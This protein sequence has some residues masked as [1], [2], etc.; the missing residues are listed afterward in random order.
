L[1]TTN[2]RI[3]TDRASDIEHQLI[4][5][6]LSSF[7]TGKVTSKQIAGTNAAD[8]SKEFIAFLR[9]EGRRSKTIVKYEGI[10]RKFVEFIGQSNVGVLSNVTLALVDAYRETYQPVLGERSMHFEGSLLKRFFSWCVDRQLMSNNPLAKRTFKKPKARP[11]GGPSLEQIDAILAASSPRRQPIV[12][13]AAFA[14]IRIGEILRLRVEDI[15]FDSNWIH[16]VSRSGYETKT[17]DTWKVPIHPRLRTILAEVPHGKTGWYFTALPSRKYPSG[18]HQVNPRDANA[19]FGKILTKLGIPTGRAVGFTFHSL[20]SSFKTIC[21]HSG[22]PKEVVDVWQ[23]HSP[24]PA[25]SNLYYKLSD[26]ESQRLIRLAK[27]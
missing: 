25:A 5:G 22:I 11:R 15:D 23:N 7:D 27:F 6:L 16:V 21:I 8:A 10:L 19:N 3:A 24:G 14:G 17:G 4:H 20:R 1:E 13:V 18:G 9:T 12:A 2:K 26:D